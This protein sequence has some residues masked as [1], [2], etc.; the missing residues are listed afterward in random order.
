MIVAPL[1]ISLGHALGNALNLFMLFII[2]VHISSLVFYNEAIKYDKIAVFMMIYLFYMTLSMVYGPKEA[3]KSS[4]FPFIAAITILPYY[5]QLLNNA[6]KKYISRCI[7]F[8][9]II[10]VFIVVYDEFFRTQEVYDSRLYVYLGEY[11]DPNYFSAGIIF[12]ILFN[13]SSYLHSKKIIDI[14]LCVVDIIILFLMGSRGGLMAI[15]VAAY[16]LIL[17]N[18]KNVVKTGIIVLVVALIAYAIA[19]RVLPEYMAERLKLSNV[20][21]STGSG[22]TII[23]NNFAEIYKNGNVLTYLFGF[24]RGSCKYLYYEYTN[25]TYYLPHNMYIKTLI[26]GGI[27]GCFLLLNI[28][29]LC[30]KKAIKEHN[31]LACSIL[32]AFLI[33]G[34]FLDMDDT[35]TMWIIFLFLYFKFFEERG[36]SFVAE[37][38]KSS[39]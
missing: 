26:E 24:G 34:S 23:W 12:I 21:G 19:I 5:Q 31:F 15:L 1:D 22:R 36:F 20:F 29:A 16:L 37:N 4:I 2:A 13:L 27:I 28:M 10:L 39:S 25:G 6:E 3:W 9:S 11:A 14:S 32:V 7:R 35:R 30:F 38:N 18:N 17:L 8:F 33:S